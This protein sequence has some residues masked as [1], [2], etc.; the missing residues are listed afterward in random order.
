MTT[1]R[2]ISRIASFIV[3]AIV[4]VAT[5]GLAVY[6][7]DT[8]TKSTTSISTS[9]VSG[10]LTS[11]TSAYNVSQENISI[12]GYPDEIAINGKI[13]YVTDMVSNNITVIDTATGSA[14][15]DVTLRSTPEFGI[16]FDPR[17]DIVYVPV[18]GCINIVNTSN[19]CL[20]PSTNHYGAGIVEIN[21]ST[22]NIV[23]QIPIGV[24]RIALDSSTNTIWATSSGPYLN[25]SDYL[26]GIDVRNGSL[27]A[28]IS[29]SAYPL[30]IAVNPISNRIY[31]A[32]CA[33]V[34]SLAC[35]GAEVIIVN[36]TS[37][38]IQGNVSLPYDALFNIV[39]DPTNSVLYV[40]GTG[41][42]LT[43]ISIDGNSG[44]IL[45]TSNLAGSCAGPGGGNLDV[46]PSTGK[47]YASFPA[48][49]YF[50]IIDGTTGKIANMLDIGNSNY[51]K[52]DANTNGVYITVSNSLLIFPSQR[53]AI[54]QVNYSEFSR[55]T[56]LP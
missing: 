4:L 11:S 25:S 53:I 21:A 8:I 29:I 17:N 45:L 26:Y 33:P 34:I 54:G 47:V 32:A 49:K 51:V 5:P 28:N 14:M 42:N 40:L 15:T 31:L 46:N 43:F 24:S 22:N 37:K 50:L 55:N 19:S 36:G 12:A 6:E 10:A 9:T 27:I 35:V 13:A 23:G 20:S 3:I 38:S 52:F 44:E 7:I 39:V 56:C 41:E 30:D 16:T 2:A 18:A 1:L 48:Q